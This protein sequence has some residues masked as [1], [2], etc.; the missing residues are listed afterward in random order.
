MASE[1]FFLHALP[2]Q[3]CTLRSDCAKA[4]AVGLGNLAT[5]EEVLAAG[6]TCTVEGIET[7]GP[8]MLATGASA[9]DSDEEDE[10]ESCSEVLTSSASSCSCC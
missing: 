6:A 1:P 8:G 2:V 10:D 9:S 3:T 5:G 7:A 4:G